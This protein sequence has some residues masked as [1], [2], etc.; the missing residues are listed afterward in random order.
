MAPVHRW[1][2]SRKNKYIKKVAIEQAERLI[3][4]VLKKRAQGDERLGAESISS[5]RSAMT[6]EVAKSIENSIQR[7]RVRQ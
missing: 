4:A 5:L 2:S 3:S 1:P 7:L 6:Q